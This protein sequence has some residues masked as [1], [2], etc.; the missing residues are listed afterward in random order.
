[1][2]ANLI[3]LFKFR[4]NDNLKELSFLLDYH[5]GDMELEFS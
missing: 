4:L 5:Y 3:N 1:M 2:Q